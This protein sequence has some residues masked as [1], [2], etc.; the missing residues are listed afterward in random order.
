M[1]P[2]LQF[3]EIIE[4]K[5]GVV[6]VAHKQC[7]TLF[8]DHV[9]LFK[10]ISFYIYKDLRL[11]ILGLISHVTIITRMSTFCPVL[12]VLFVSELLLSFEAWN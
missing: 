12:N 1:K 5:N 7:K 10:I 4:I 3:S 2:W 9:V 11:K 6:P 8:K